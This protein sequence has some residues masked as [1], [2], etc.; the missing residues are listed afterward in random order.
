MDPKLKKEKELVKR[1]Q[2]VGA[3]VAHEGKCTTEGGTK[4]ETEEQT[5][6]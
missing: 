2:I 4:K 6:I 1:A 3:E 5:E